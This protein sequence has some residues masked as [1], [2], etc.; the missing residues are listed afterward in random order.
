MRRCWDVALIGDSFID[1]VLSGFTDWPKPG[2]EAFAT[3]YVREAGGGAV[4]TACGLARLGRSAALVSVVGV[5]DG[6]WLLRRVGEFGVD[7]SQVR[8]SGPYTGM[9]TAVS[10]PSDR[11]LFTYLGP[12]AELDLLLRDDRGI[13]QLSEARH[14]HIAYEPERGSAMA[15]CE[16]LRAA[17]CT[18]S[19]DLGWHEAWL[20]DPAS[21]DLI[22]LTTIFLP[23]ESEARA[24]TGK[25]DPRAMLDF[26]ERRGVTSVAIKLGERGA[27]M[28][29]AGVF[30]TC[31][32]FKVDAVD[33]TGAGDAF[34]AGFIHALLDNVPPERC[35]AV[36]CACG[37][38]STRAPGAL[39]ALPSREE[40]EAR[41]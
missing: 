1:H 16:R 12:S 10:F 13:E 41:L 8:R 35:L 18:I 11:A 34:D 2:Q 36:A 19:L 17:S 32:G 6:D 24:I 25:E 38:L 30:Y 31:A 37:A 33:T 15:A 39:Q 3:N 9:T 7:T 22:R 21:L 27:V 14:V 23:N 26:F 4:N 28:S 40:L 20:R 29:Q 5:E